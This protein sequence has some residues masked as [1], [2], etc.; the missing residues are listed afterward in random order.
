VLERPERARDAREADDR[1]QHEVGLAMLEE[2]DDVAA[3]LDV[4][5]T[6]AAASSS[7]GCEPDESA[8][9]E[10]SGFAAITSSA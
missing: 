4:L 7:S 2:L 6:E 1:V 9:T 8:Q 3:D 5:D 10:S